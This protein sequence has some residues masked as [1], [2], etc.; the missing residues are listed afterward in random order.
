MQCDDGDGKH[1][2][3]MYHIHPANIKEPKSYAKPGNRS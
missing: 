2:F 1:Y 3:V